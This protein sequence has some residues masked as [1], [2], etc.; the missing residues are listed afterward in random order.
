MNI[1]V[2]LIP[3][4]HFVGWAESNR[5][6]LASN[7]PVHLTI[8]SRFKIKEEQPAEVVKLISSILDIS[9]FNCLL[10]GPMYIDGNL[11]WL[12]C[13][14]NSVGYSKLESLH[15]Q[16]VQRIRASSLYLK[17]SSL[18]AYEIDGFRPHVTLQWNEYGV[19]KPQGNHIIEA[20]EANVTFM[21]WCLFEYTDDSS[22]RFSKVVY[23][24]KFD[25]L[26]KFRT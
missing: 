14:S 12:E 10:K 25:N 3:N 7:F 16:L 19:F 18:E 8:K 6:G 9:P 17:G 4:T 13:T 5:S 21:G 24:K 2:A 20:I 22:R 26:R 23:E 15:R 1:A 11:K